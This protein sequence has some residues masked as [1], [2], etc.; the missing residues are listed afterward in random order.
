MTIG[1]RSGGEAAMAYECEVLAD[2]INPDG[3]R[4]T[5]LRMLFP[6]IL[7]AEANV[8]REGIARNASSSRAIPARLMID[9]VR[10]AP[11]IPPVFYAA[12]RGMAVREPLDGDGQRKAHGQFARAVDAALDGAERLLESG[13]HKSQI[14]RVLEPYAWT[15]WIVTL[16]EETCRRL[17]RERDALDADPAWWPLCAIWRLAYDDS[18]PRRVAWG[19]WHLPYGD[20][21]PD[22]W[23]GDDGLWMI[24]GRCCRVSY[25]THDGRF[26]P[27]DDEALARREYTA[28]HRSPLEHANQSTPG[29]WGPFTGWRSHRSILEGE[30]PPAVSS[31]E[32]REQV[33]MP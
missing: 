18:E 11:F 8:Y 4:L 14:N 30:P 6:R 9:R 33:V 21:I 7:L 10:A 23:T 15:D 27:S 1:R 24:G 5:T 16:T 22:H 25:T 2:S 20:H 3:Q 12:G 31:T 26:A 28:G 19:G 29:R 17:L 13:V 32:R